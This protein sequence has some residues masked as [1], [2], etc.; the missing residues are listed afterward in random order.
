MSEQVDE[1]IALKD[2]TP[3]AEAIFFAYIP[4]DRKPVQINYWDGKAF[5]DGAG[6]RTDKA[7]HWHEVDLYRPSPPKD[8]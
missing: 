8:K 5:C 4:L 3:Q 7:T 1:W 6:H 2:R